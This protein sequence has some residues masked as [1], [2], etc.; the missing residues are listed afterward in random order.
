L[1]RT[2]GLGTIEVVVSA[3]FSVIYICTLRGAASMKPTSGTFIGTVIGLMIVLLAPSNY[4]N[5]EQDLFC[6]LVIF[7]VSG[8]ILG[9]VI[10][11]LRHRRS[12]SAEVGDP[13][14]GRGKS[15][16]RPV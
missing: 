3:D 11:R 10:D 4:M 7:P 6:W 16:T 9:T 13:A 8:A 5:S 1:A 15:G 14:S 12:R 2:L